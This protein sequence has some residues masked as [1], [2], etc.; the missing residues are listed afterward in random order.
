M[1]SPFGS[2]AVATTVLGTTG[3]GGGGRRR[4]RELRAAVERE[5]GNR[6]IGQPES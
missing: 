4:R 3:G 2:M 5:D 1:R 6:E